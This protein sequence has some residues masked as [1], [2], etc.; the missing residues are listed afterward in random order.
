M[1][2]KLIAYFGE[3]GSFSHLAA[4]RR[5]PKA[6]TLSCPTV[7]NAFSQLKDGKVEQIVVP[8]ENA[9]SGLITDTID[10]LISL[11]YQPEHDFRI[12]ECL[13]MKV[14]LALLAPRKTGKIRTIY[15]HFAPFTHSRS[16]LQKHYPD[17]R[18]IVVTS[19]SEAAR[20][21]QKDPNGAAIAGAHTAERYG[22]KVIHPKVASDVPN[23]TKFFVVGLPLQKSSAPTHTS[24]IFELAHRPGSLAAVLQVLARRKLNLTRIESRPIPGRFSEYRFAIEF[25]G[26]PGQESCDAALKQMSRLTP[27]NAVIGSY[28]ILNFK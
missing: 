24:L 16:W 26:V 3:E 13:A 12:R 19:T 1:T 10:Q 15:S 27:F 20:R 18:Q 22:L 9:S 8:I 28:P 11:I 4:E 21:A 17:A 14:E 25:E 7:E 2:G 6:A 23:R 5:F